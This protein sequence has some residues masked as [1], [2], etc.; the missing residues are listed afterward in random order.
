M[1]KKLMLISLMPCAMIAMDNKSNRSNATPV[2]NTVSR[3]SDAGIV[4][5]SVLMPMTIAS[6]FNPLIPTALVVSSIGSKLYAG[7][8][9]SKKN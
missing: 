2:A 9:A 5:Y 6:T 7:Y 3:V 4:G 1:L 8:Y